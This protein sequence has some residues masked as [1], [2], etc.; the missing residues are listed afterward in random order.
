MECVVVVAVALP[1]PLGCAAVGGGT[2]ETLVAV[3]R[4]NG[5]KPAA[6]RAPACKSA[7]RFCWAADVVVA[8]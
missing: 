1:P 6:A 7:A 8:P 2:T 3:G 4:S 5:G